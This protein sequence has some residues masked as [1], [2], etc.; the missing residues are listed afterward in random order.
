M[1][2]WW[3]DLFDKVKDAIGGRQPSARAAARCSHTADRSR[4]Q[5]PAPI[6]NLRPLG[7]DTRPEQGQRPDYSDLDKVGD[8]GT[9]PKAEGDLSLPGGTGS[10]QHT[11]IGMTEQVAPAMEVGAAALVA[12]VAIAVFAPEAVAAAAAPE[13]GGGAAAEA[14]AASVMLGVDSGTVGVFFKRGHSSWR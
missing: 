11:G 13:I 8:G 7:L 1:S 14:G 4:S 3:Q 6:P 2:P 10:E 5:R 9:E 12:G